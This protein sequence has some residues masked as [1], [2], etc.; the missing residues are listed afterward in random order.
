ML[1]YARWQSQRQSESPLS[2]HDVGETAQMSFITIDGPNASGKTTLAEALSEEL[3][4]RQLSVV[5]TR[6]PTDSPLGRMVREFEGTLTGRSYA[7]LVAADRHFHV[8]E[9]IRPALSTGAI[10]I[11]TRYIESSLVLQHMDGVPR[12]FVWAIHEDLEI[13][14]L[15]V[16]LRVAP[17]I[18][19]ERLRQ[20]PSH[21]RFEAAANS[22]AR[23]CQEYEEVTE[24]LMNDGRFKVFAIDYSEKSIADAVVLILSRAKIPGEIA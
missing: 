4:R 2:I 9:I 11:S 7:C 8:S 13:P 1:P 16:H 12:Q 6:E 14:D 24:L 10:V 15:S 23:E 5:L 21:S 3:Q 20:R 17:H 19:Q 22:S 18:L